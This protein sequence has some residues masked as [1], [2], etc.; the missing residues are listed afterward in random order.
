MRKESH[1][2]VTQQVTEEALF[3][4][5]RWTAGL[6]Q[7]ARV[8]W[9]RAEDENAP[10]ASKMNALEF[11]K[12]CY[13][14]RLQMLIGSHAEGKKAQDHVVAMKWRNGPYEPGLSFR[15]DEN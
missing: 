9:K 14:L 12:N 10:A 5:S 4:F 2:S 1:K 3:E 13:N 8:A 11:L 7:M 6:D 15:R